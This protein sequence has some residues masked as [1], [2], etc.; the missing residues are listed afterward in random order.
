M[1]AVARMIGAVA[2]TASLTFTAPSE[3]KSVQKL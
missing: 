1:H 2:I 3:L